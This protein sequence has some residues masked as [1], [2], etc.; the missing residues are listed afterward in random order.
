M[1]KTGNETKLVVTV[2]VITGESSSI[3]Q[4]VTLPVF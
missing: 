3:N 4:C 2:F 1:Y